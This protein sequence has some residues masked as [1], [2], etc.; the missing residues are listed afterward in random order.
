MRALKPDDL[1]DQV[2][3]HR[4]FCASDLNRHELWIRDLESEVAVLRAELEELKSAR[5]CLIAEGAL[6]GLP[7]TPPAA[8]APTAR[9]ESG[10]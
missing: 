2:A 6:V 7:P 8:P 9:R 5:P 10:S 4:L 3:E 1:A